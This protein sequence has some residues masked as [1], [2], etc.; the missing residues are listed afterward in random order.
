MNKKAFTILEAMI[1]III[2]SFSLLYVYRMQMGSIRR[3][4]KWK[5][6]ILNVFPIKEQLLSYY[7]N[8]PAKYTK[9]LKHNI[10]TQGLTITTELKEVASKSS[11]KQFRDTINIVE[12]TGQWGSKRRLRK[13]SLITF[14]AKKDKDEE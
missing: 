11:L 9:P 2:L 8:P 14:I 1:A 10:D 4:G 7:F 5:Q 3:Y 12:S 6:Q 13:V